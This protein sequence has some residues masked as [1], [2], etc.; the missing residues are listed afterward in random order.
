MGEKY[1]MV[2]TLLVV[3]KISISIMENN[4]ETL[5]N[6]ENRTAIL[7]SNSTPRDIPEGM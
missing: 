3:M 7:F 6:T 2:Q 5:Q 1:M 4:I